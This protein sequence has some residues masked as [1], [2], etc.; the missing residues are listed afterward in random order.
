MKQL[1]LLRGLPGAGKTTLANF[2]NQ[3]IASCASISADDYFMQ[4]GEY[5]FDISKLG[6]AHAECRWLTDWAME[7]GTETI[8]IHNTN[9]TEKEMKDYFL[10]AAGHDYSVVSLVVENRH[11]N[12]SVHG[13][14]EE[15]LL[16]MKERFHVKLL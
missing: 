12:S 14:P 4:E 9:T 6:A 11:G 16:K 2:L 13:V 3:N 15:T 7:T 8:V 10:L 5:V 1:I